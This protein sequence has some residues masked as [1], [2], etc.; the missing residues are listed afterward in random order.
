MPREIS[1]ENGFITT[2]VIPNRCKYSKFFK[3]ESKSEWESKAENKAVSFSKDKLISNF[4]KKSALLL[5]CSSA[6]LDLTRFSRPNSSVNY[7]TVTD[8]KIAGMAG[9]KVA[10]NITGNAANVT[11]TVE[12]ANGGTGAATAA[13]A[14]TNLGLGN[15]DNTS[16]ANKPVSTATQTALDL[17]APLA[18]PTFTGDA[19]AV[20]AAAGDNDVSLATT[21]FVTSAVSTANGTNANL[22]GV[23]TSL[24]NATII[25]DGALSIAKTSGLQ[26]ALDTKAPLASPTLTGTPMAPT[27]AAGTSTTQIA[28]TAFVTAATSAGMAGSGTANY[29]PKFS[30]ASSLGNSSISDDGT[31]LRIGN[32]NGQAGVYT[33]VNSDNNTRLMVT[34]GR[35]FESIKMAFAGDPYN[36]ELSFNWYSSAWKMRTERSGGDIT[37]LS[38]WR[39]AGASTTEHLRLT[40]EG[41]LGIGINA[42]QEKLDVAGNIKFSGALLPNSSAGTAGQVLTSAGANA[43]PTWTTPSTTATAYS[44]TLPM[45]NGGTGATTL[46]GIVKGN[47]SSAMTAATAGT[48]Y[49]AGTASLATGIVK[50]TTTTGALSIASAADFPT[51]NQNTTGSAATLTTARTIH[52]GSFNGSAD[53]TNIIGSAFG[54][55]GNGFTKFTG[56]TTAEKTFTLPDATATILTSNAAVTV[57]QGGTG[58]T[59]LTANNVLLGNGTSAIQAVAPGTSGNVLTSNGTTWASTAPSGGGLPTSGNTAGDMLYWNGTAWIKVS[60]GSNNKF[61]VFVNNAPT[62]APFIGATDVYNP[63]TGK[64]W[65]DRNLGAT[66]VATSSTDA[67]SYGSI[68]QWGRATDGHQ[69]RTTTTTSAT[70]TTLS[71]TDTPGNSNFISIPSC[72]GTLNWRSSQNDNLW[73]GVSGTNNPCPSGYRLPTEAEWIAESATWG[74]LAAGAFA[75]VLKLPVAGVRSVCGGGLE[76]VGVGGIYWSS[77]VSG[78]D[79]KTLAIGSSTTSTFASKRGDGRSVRCIKN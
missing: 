7:S 46:S 45:G 21:E 32:P 15:V 51:L 67:N 25:A 48:D 35:E 17:K 70:T 52:G 57:E 76:I 47:G 64:V 41:K 11:G 22:T 34:G 29:I 54:G 42:P 33:A 38:F 2:R 18:A 73:Q 13:G 55:T 8:A 65:M 50:S 53:V 78:T 5:K 59:T 62:W 9:S 60:G 24:G 44:G 77:T 27:A 26:T 40:S 16:D 79:A 28:T 31:G 49:S 10:G 43:V 37:H 39:T 58:A 61:L 72:S 30:T 23:V 12:V 74:T 63:S 71:S 3:S 20:T 56:P 19:K 68:Y 4:F 66:Q 75:S 69:L 1:P 14:R 36:T 6:L